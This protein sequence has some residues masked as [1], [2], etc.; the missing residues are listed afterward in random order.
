MKSIIEELYYGNIDPQNSGFEDD[1]S[2][3]RTLR[4]ISENEDWLTEH[5]AGEEKK[6]FLDFADAW[7]SFNGDST[8]DGFVT[9][10]RL[11]ACFVMDTFL[12]GPPMKDEE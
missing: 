12:S 10:F 9:G 3:Q 6:R 11:G 1:E 5:L 2:V 8:L 7:S 4:A